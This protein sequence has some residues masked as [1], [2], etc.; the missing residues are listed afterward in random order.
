MKTIEINGKEY[1]VRYIRKGRRRLVTGNRSCRK[2]AFREECVCPFDCTDY[3][4]HNKS[5]RVTHYAYFQKVNP[6]SPWPDIAIGLVALAVAAVLGLLCSGCSSK[7]A[8]QEPTGPETGVTYERLYK[9][10][11]KSVEVDK[12]TYEGHDYLLF[13]GRTA[14]TPFALHSESCPCKTKE[15]ER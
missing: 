7:P 4:K 2:C 10:F 1:R 11:G 5:G 14:T 13:S 12:V 3:Y 8:V 6:D 9:D 15:G